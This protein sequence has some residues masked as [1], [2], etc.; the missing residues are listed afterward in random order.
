MTTARLGSDRG[1]ITEIAPPFSSVQRRRRTRH[2]PALRPV[3]SRPR[4]LLGG[5]HLTQ[6]PGGI[7]RAGVGVVVW[8][9]WRRMN[10]YEPGSLT[11]PRA[12][13]RRIHLSRERL[14]A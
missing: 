10:D 8:T 6:T 7:T 2:P 4:R 1:H 11:D 5:V 12:I 3:A 14:A 9:K 13:G